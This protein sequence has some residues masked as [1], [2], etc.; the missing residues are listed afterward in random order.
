M[1]GRGGGGE[2]GGRWLHRHR[3]H[4]TRTRYKWINTVNHFASTVG[5]AHSPH[6]VQVALSCPSARAVGV[7][8]A[9]DPWVARLT[10]LRPF[11]P[12]ADMLVVIST[13]PEGT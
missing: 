3:T 8:M 10:Q 6:L 4:S 9:S 2:R 11:L 13:T 5:P 7:Y 12:G 1:E